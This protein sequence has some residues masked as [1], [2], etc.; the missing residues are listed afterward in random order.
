VC[1]R[2]NHCI[3][4]GVDDRDGGEDNEGGSKKR[5]AAAAP[6]A[7]RGAPFLAP[8]SWGSAAP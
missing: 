3:Q 2:M 4:G 1:G 8:A 6:A 5:R 7:M